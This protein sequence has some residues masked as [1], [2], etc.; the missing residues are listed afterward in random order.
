MENNQD[1]RPP[2]YWDF[3][4][5]DDKRIYRKIY[6]ILANPNEANKMQPIQN[7]KF[8]DIIDAIDI[9]ENIDLQDKWKRCLVCGL[10]KLSDFIAVNISQLK[11][12]I[13]T[14]KS[15]I[16]GS[17]KKCGFDNCIK[18]AEGCNKL[19]EAIP[20]LR[21]NPSERRKWTLRQYQQKGMKSIQN[22]AESDFSYD[23]DQNDS[24]K[25]ETDDDDMMQL[26]ANT[27]PL[28]LDSSLHFN[29]IDS[30]IENNEHITEPEVAPYTENEIKQM[31][32]TT[33]NNLPID[34]DDLLN[35]FELNMIPAN[36]AFD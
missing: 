12:L 22:D 1:F 15:S 29:V 23:S 4:S 13:H 28:K 33:G 8:T 16:N 34:D 14:S 36:L 25:S 26:T 20:F 2:K 7:K 32:T 30:N 11:Y 31:C 10:V 9:F 17:L 5:I 21:D 6:D 18:K 3:L 24:H 35:F 27:S 19:I